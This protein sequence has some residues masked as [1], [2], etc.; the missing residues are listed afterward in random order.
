[1]PF[2][3]MER[4][5]FRKTFI[6]Y[7]INPTNLLS[8]PN[9]GICLWS[10]FRHI[11]RKRKKL[12]LIKN[13]LFTVT[14]KN[15][16]M[17]FSYIFFLLFTQFLL[18]WLDFAAVEYKVNILNN[19]TILVSFAMELTFAAS[20]EEEDLIAIVLLRSKFFEFSLIS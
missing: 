12:M 9:G 4:P 20:K 13:G 2:D 18:S 15:I 17:F 6:K 16:A 7:F 1:V 8:F 19:F 5:W 3:K 14:R 10:I 11:K